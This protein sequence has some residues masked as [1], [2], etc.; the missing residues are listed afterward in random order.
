MLIKESVTDLETPQGPMHT[1][2]YEPKTGDVYQEKK[3]PGL[4]FFS[5]IFQRTPGIER[6]AKWLCG[7]GY[8]L[9]TIYVYTHFSYLAPLLSQLTSFRDLS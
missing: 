9:N 7:H 4:I 5:A 1:Y 3:Y 6:M 2:I 8:V